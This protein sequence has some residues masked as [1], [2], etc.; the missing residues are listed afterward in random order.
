MVEQNVTVWL[1]NIHK[2]VF[3]FGLQSNYDKDKLSLYLKHAQFMCYAAG[4][5]EIEK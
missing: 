5:L 2:P 4:V 1:R 3:L